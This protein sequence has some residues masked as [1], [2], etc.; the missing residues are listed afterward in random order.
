MSEQDS[1]KKTSTVEQFVIASNNPESTKIMIDLSQISEKAGT[2]LLDF[3]NG[4]QNVVKIKRPANE[5]TNEKTSSVD[6]KAFEPGYVFKKEMLPE[7]KKHLAGALCLEKNNDGR[8]LVVS[9]EMLDNGGTLQQF[10]D[11]ISSINERGGYSV[12]MGTHDQWSTLLDNKEFVRLADID[13]D[14]AYWVD[15]PKHIVPDNAPVRWP[16]ENTR[17]MYAQ[18]G[19]KRYG[20]YR[21]LEQDDVGGRA[22]SVEEEFDLIDVAP[23]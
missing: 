17:E 3:G 21:D 12:S 9:T 15:E 16:Y 5:K 2:I 22:F 10:T 19:G 6:I 4:S 1:N 14:K 13:D 8:V 11:K 20:R 7:N 18:Y 23:E